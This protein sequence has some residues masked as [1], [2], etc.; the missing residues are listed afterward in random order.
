MKINQQ[1]DQT[2][3][4]AARRAQ[5]DGV[6]ALSLDAR[7]FLQDATASCAANMTAL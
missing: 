5:D 3:H 2:I 7:V 6:S 4:T 1:F